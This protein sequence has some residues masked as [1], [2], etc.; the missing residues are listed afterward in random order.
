MQF[1]FVELIFP[2]ESSWRKDGFSYGFFG[3]A[4]CVGSD[5]WFISIMED[6]I[7]FSLVEPCL[8]SLY[9]ASPGATR[10]AHLVALGR[11]VNL[12][13]A[14]ECSYVVYDYAAS[15]SGG[16]ETRSGRFSSVSP[17]HPAIGSVAVDSNI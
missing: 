7:W 15:A 8:R 3:V 10:T 9:R 12:R 1:V 17:N 11:K 6:P 16:G 14:T 13:G 4:A 2:H 5:V